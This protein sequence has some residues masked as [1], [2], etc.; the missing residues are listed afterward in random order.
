MDSFVKI[1]IYWNIAMW[2]IG[3]VVVTGALVCAALAVYHLIF[4]GWAR[5]VAKDCRFNLWLYQA[6]REWERQGNH[7]PD[8]TTLSVGHKLNRRMREL[9]AFAMEHGY[10]ITVENKPRTPL[11]MGNSYMDFNVRSARHRYQKGDTA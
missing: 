6:M 8:G 2:A 5:K 9:L 1:A 3:A 7:R 10:V 11:A 4:K